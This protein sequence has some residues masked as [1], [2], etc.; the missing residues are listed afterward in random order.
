MDLPRHPVTV[1]NKRFKNGFST[2]NRKKSWWLLLGRSFQIYV[3]T[4]NCSAI[5]HLTHFVSSSLAFARGSVK[6]AILPT[7][8]FHLAI[9][10]VEPTFYK[11]PTFNKKRRISELM[12]EKFLEFCCLGFFLKVW[13]DHPPKNVGSA[14]RVSM[15]LGRYIC[16]H[17]WFVDFLMSFHACMRKKQPSVLRIL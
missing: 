11:T 12:S 17:L 3:L 8:D 13:Y 16:P 5:G 6:K 14:H 7:W 15:T 4:M 2:A 10:M 9:T 1:P